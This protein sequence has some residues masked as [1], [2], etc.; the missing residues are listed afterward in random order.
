LIEKNKRFLERKIRRLSALK[1]KSKE[2]VKVGLPHDSGFHKPPERES[3]SKNGRKSRKTPEE[4]TLVQIGTVNEFG[5]E[6]GK[7]P[8]RSFLRSTIKK[9]KLKYKKIFAKIANQLIDEPDNFKILLGK[10]GVIAQGDVQKTIRD[11]SEPP[12]APMTI[13]IKGADNP[14]VDTGQLGSAITYVID[15]KN[16]NDI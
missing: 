16:S 12:N 10:I 1:E 2:S 14:L 15:K 8:E 4:V 5:S 6:N 9:E 3:K 13:A 7:I 11:L